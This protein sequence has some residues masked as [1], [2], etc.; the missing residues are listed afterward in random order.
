MVPALGKITTLPVVTMEES[1]CRSFLLEGGGV[2]SDR[3]VFDEPFCACTHHVGI[4]IHILYVSDRNACDEH[5][6]YVERPAT[7]RHERGLNLIGVSPFT[8]ILFRL[9]I[10]LNPLAPLPVVA[11]ATACLLSTAIVA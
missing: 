2:S 10:F 11:N 8:L 3:L 9:R 4:D 1:E 6:R 5:D 7:A